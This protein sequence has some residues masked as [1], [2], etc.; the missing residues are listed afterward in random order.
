MVVKAEAKSQ[1]LSDR[2]P[3]PSALLDMGR[4]ALHAPLPHLV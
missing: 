1:R 2:A 3:P 4:L